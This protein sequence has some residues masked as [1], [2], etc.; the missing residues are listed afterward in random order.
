[1]SL[2][3]N[4]LIVLFIAFN[5]VMC[6]QPRNKKPTVEKQKLTNEK[7]TA[8][9]GKVHVDKET[10]KRPK[11]TSPKSKKGG[12]VSPKNKQPVSPKIKQPVSP[13][14]Q[15]PVSPKIQQQV[16]PKIKTAS[17]M[18]LDNH[19]FIKGAKIS[20]IGNDQ[21]FAITQDDGSFFLII[22][23]R[24]LNLDET[25]SAT[26]EELGIYVE[27]N[28]QEGDFGV[29]KTNI[30][31]IKGETLDIGN[32][33]LQRTGNIQGRVELAE[34]NDF[35]GVD[36][37]IP[38]TSFSAK[39]DKDGN[40]KISNIPEGSW[41][42]RAEQDGFNHSTVTK[43][44][45]IANETAQ[46]E[47]LVLFVSTGVQG[48][49]VIADGVDFIESQKVKVAL[50]FSEETTIMRWSEDTTFSGIEYQVI[51][52]DQLNQGFAIIE[53]EFK[54]DGEKV[55]YAQFSDPDGIENIVSDKINIDT[56]APE[57]A[58]QLN[59]LGS[60][61]DQ[62][63]AIW[64]KSSSSDLANQKIQFFKGKACEEVYKTIDLGDDSVQQKTLNHVP[65]ADYSFKIMSIDRNGYESLSLCSPAIE[66]KFQWN[67]LG[68][69]F[70]TDVEINESASIFMAEGIPYLAYPHD[71]KTKPL[72][73]FKYVDNN[74][75]VIAELEGVHP[76]FTSLYVK[77]QVI[78]LAYSSSTEPANVKKYEEGVWTSVG[79]E[80]FSVWGAKN[81]TLKFDQDTPY[82]AYEDQSINGGAINFQKWN[83]S[84]WEQMGYAGMNGM[85]YSRNESYSFEID[86]QN[87]IPYLVLTNYTKAGQ[88]QDP[89]LVFRFIN[90]TWESLHPQFDIHNTKKTSLFIEDGVVYISYS[91]GVNGEE[92][93]YVIKYENDEW[94]QL[95]S[96]F[97]T[98]NT[99]SQSLY[100]SKGIPYVAYVDEQEFKSAKVTY[101][102]D[103]EWSILGEDVISSPNSRFIEIVGNE[104]HLFVFTAEPENNFWKGSA[105]EYTQFMQVR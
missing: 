82:V 23:D 8:I 3:N 45:V 102:K 91:A 61:Q 48:K 92:I 49:V 26:P 87:H 4:T 89:L 5:L 43:I 17:G 53:Y 58:T 13:K 57:V 7:Y 28:S 72:R 6:N 95:G 16:S 71:F 37:F 44:N 36:V 31:V 41:T 93:G 35:T 15:Q 90:D 20:L 18:N 100:V 75:E 104:D 32:L 78:Y 88:N 79:R 81:I 97:S 38:G 85:Q 47:D 86:E 66:S 24:L 64:K 40:Y 98:M 27:Y 94:S 74:W 62:I 30:K 10:L 76:E 29:Q 21:Q 69:R 105:L 99:T 1:M 77:N 83:G 67:Y 25:K 73:I 101:Y 55:L 9:K 33:E 84:D 96:E 2:F 39:T 54:T 50:Y 68:E 19:K 60:S 80:N 22:P 52:K 11:D 103:G 59:W 34:Q 46:I 12:P 14:I 51:T 42:L 70:F 65:A 56:S 63:T